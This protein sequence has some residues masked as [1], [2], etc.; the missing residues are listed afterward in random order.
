[1][2]ENLAPAGNRE[3]LDRAVAAG[4]DAVYLGYA[5]YSARAGAGNFDE[6]ALREAVHFAHLHHVRVHVTVNTL[7]KDGELAGVMDVLRLLNEVRVDAVLVQDLGVMKLARECFP[8]LP[9]HASTQMAIHNAAGVRFCRAQGMTRVVLARECSLAEIAKCAAEGIEIEVFGHGA[10]C[11]AVSG[12]CLF[13][14]MIGGRSGNRGRCAQPCRLLYE[15]RGKT[16]AWLSPR[17]V[18]MRD[19]LPE[20][21]KAGACSIKLEGRLKRPEYVAAVAGSYRRGIDG[22]QAGAFRKADEQERDGLL[23]IFQ[24]GGFMDGYAMGCEDAGVI[25]ESRVNHGGVPVGTIVSVSG[26]MAKMR[27]DRDLADGDGLQLRTRQGD[28]EMIYSGHSVPAGETATLRLR[29]DMRIARGD[30]VV[31]LTSSAQLAEAQ[32]LTIPAIPCDMTLV[33]L[34]GEPLTLTVTDG[35]STVTA[36]G[37]VVTAAQKRAMSEDDARRNLSKTGDTPF[38]LRELTVFTQ[39]AFV[40][41]SALNSIRREVLE[42][43]EKQRAE[44]FARPAGR[45]LPMPEAEM[46]GQATPPVIIVRSAEQYA[47]VRELE[48]RI[49]WYPEDFRPDALEEGLRAMEGGVWLHL[50]MKCEQATL[51]M[52]H[53][54]VTAHKDKLGGVVLGSVGQ[55]GMQWPVPFGAGEGVPVMNRLA[56]RFLLEQGCEFVTASGE[57]S[58][59]ELNKLLK[60]TPN[61]IV[62]AYGRAQLMLL[63]HCPARTYLGLDKGHASCRLC[64]N[65]NPDALAGTAFTDR[66]GVRFPL[67][68]LR[69]PEGCLVRL[70]N[71]VPTDLLSRVRSEG[72]TPLMTLCNESGA[73]L[74]EAVGAWMGERNAAETTSAHWNRPVE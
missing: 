74:R 3:A 66:R 68:R 41:V 27:C 57:L 32:T 40:P 25:C 20:L 28:A 5:A 64:D 46:T 1:M 13:S 58:A 38:A 69:L 14:S 11:V 55:M 24:R 4:A 9:V 73:A 22:L 49:V 18:C 56:A 60:Y 42:Q 72:Y 29:P 62:P 19:H 65:G 23:Q 59:A 43:L 12:Q 2:M 17:D 47:A 36:T 37:D 31:R 21:A 70:M 8:D 44:D 61:V 52:L 35:T 10:Q 54:F 30:A 15:Y 16:A 34:P 7:V 71:S 51:D 48:A 39:D 45:E 26:G 6:A 53:T 33:A 67:M 63:H 50:P